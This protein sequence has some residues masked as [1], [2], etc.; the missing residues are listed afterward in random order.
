MKKLFIVAITAL[1]FTFAAQAQ[2]ETTTIGGF[3]QGDVFIEGTLGLVALMTKIL[4]KNLM[5]LTLLQKLV[6][7]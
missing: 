5:D 6:F 7:Y 4:T 3:E 1:G 2:E